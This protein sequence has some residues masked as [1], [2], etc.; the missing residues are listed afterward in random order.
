MKYIL[1]FLLLT[2]CANVQDN[3]TTSDKLIIGTTLAVMLYGGATMK[4]W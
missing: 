1:S 3:T 2:G 4:D